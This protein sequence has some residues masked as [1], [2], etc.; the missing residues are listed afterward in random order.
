MLNSTMVHAKKFIYAKRFDGMPKLDDFKLEV[1]AL[2][3]LKGGGKLQI[4][5]PI[6][7]IR[8][9]IFLFFRCARRSDVLER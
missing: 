7:K 6:R 9:N 3:K 4:S 1:E 8:Q 5:P 2:P